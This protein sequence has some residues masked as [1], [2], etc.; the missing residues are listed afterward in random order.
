MAKPSRPTRASDA[1]AATPAAAFLVLDGVAD[2]VVEVP[3]PEEPVALGEPLP[4]LL[5]PLPPETSPER[6]GSET[7]EMEAVPFLQASPALEP[8]PETK[9]TAAHCFGGEGVGL[10][11]VRVVSFHTRV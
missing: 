10:A 11:V 2:G 4:P 5:L 1:G 3:V 8:V 7:K 9:F 6:S